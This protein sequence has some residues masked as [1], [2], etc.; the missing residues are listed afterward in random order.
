MTTPANVTSTP[1]SESVTLY[2]GSTGT[3]TLSIQGL[4]FEKLNL[5]S[6]HSLTIQFQSSEQ[7]IYTLNEG[8]IPENFKAPSQVERFEI[9]MSYKTDSSLT[10]NVIIHNVSAVD[11]GEYEIYLFIHADEDY[12]AGRIFSATKYVQVQSLTPQA[13]CYITAGE[14]ASYSLEVHCRA[15]TSG[16]NVTISC[17]QNNNMLPMNDMF[18]CENDVES[19][20]LMNGSG[21]V[22]CC[23]HEL[24]DT[25]DQ[26]SCH[27]FTWVPVSNEGK[28]QTY[29]NKECGNERNAAAKMH[30]SCNTHM[31]YIC[32]FSVVLILYS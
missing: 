31:T 24:H 22:Y 21:G 9:E 11:E 26:E 8:F 13:S 18:E 23:S 15:E 27:D 6:G 7:A 4:N 1:L 20:F 10:V 32:F 25:V 5:K 2:E 16:R 28:C 12:P 29:L 30:F 14:V 19:V 17:F 3:L